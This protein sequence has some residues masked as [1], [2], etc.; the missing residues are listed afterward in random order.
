MTIAWILRHPQITS[1]LIGASRISQIEDAVAAL[2]NLNITNEELESI[3][4]ILKG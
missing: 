1:A 4:N 2:K 3:E